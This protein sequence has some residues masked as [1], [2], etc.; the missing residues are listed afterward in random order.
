MTNNIIID[1]ID[2]SEC[3]FFQTINREDY[4][5]EIDN[6]CCETYVPCSSEYKHNCYYKQ[7]KRKEQEC[8][9][10]KAQ[11]KQVKYL[12]EVQDEKLIDELA[13]ENK[14]YE[15]ALDEIA[16]LINRLKNRTPLFEMDEIA[17]DIIEIEK[18]ISKS[19]EE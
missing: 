14:K 17:K 1:G 7:L 18:I 16:E 6:C 13:T 2:V 3:K 11:L 5:V 10:L 8:E 9:E 15:Q 4:D 19:R 12:H